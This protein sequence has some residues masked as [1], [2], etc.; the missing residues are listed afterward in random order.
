MMVLRWNP[1]GEL[2]G[3]MLLSSTNYKNLHANFDFDFFNFFLVLEESEK[4]QTIEPSFL[5]ATFFDSSKYRNIMVTVWC[6]T[7]LG[8]FVTNS[9]L[10]LE[11]FL[12]FN[13]RSTILIV[14]SVG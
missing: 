4:I 8:S 11:F 1:P 6:I 2:Y 14:G 10:D 13:V 12:L 7:C 9:F 3:L 5:I